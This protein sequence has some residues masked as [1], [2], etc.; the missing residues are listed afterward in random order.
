VPLVAYL[1]IAFALNYVDRQMVYSMFPALQADLGIA[2]AKLGL[3]GSVF[4]WVY[5]LSM[6]L[7]G[8]MADTLRRDWLLVS[9]L[10]L[11]SLATL[12]CGMAGSQNEFLAWRGVM[13]LTES[14]YYPTALAMIAG[15]Y[16][17]SQRSRALG[18]HQSAQLCGVVFGGWYGGWAA[19]HTGW[20][21]AFYVA[22]LAGVVYSGVLWYGVRGR[23]AGAAPNQKGRIGALVRSK[24]YLALCGAFSAFCAIQWIF[25]AWFPTF[26]QERFG[27]SMTDS[28]WNATLFVQTATIVGILGGGALADA[29]RKR[30]RAAR[31]HV[32][33]A[34]VMLSAPFAYFTFSA[35]SL[36]AARLFSAIFG[37]FAGLL[38]ANAFA[39]AYDVIG[40][41]NRG[42][43]GGVLN[44]TGGISSTF[45]IYLAGATKD[46]IGFSG[47]LAWMMVIAIGCAT[48]LG[49]TAYSKFDEEKV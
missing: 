10:V 15:H 48:I 2:G 38:A 35:A 47:L 20:R 37:L 31:M 23:T 3:I 36:D 46:T 24:C 5:T 40:A 11:W 30:Y 27:L 43:S 32:A 45:T 6:P 21:Q 22:C 1:W 17:E 25:F 8:R 28:G 29:L 19:D 18:I 7:A 42:V 41:E 9:S 16:A 12:G 33:A 34:G 14:L 26:L 44:M 39:A 13:G 49:L 4:Q